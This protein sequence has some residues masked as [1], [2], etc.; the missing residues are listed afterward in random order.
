MFKMDSSVMKTGSFYRIKC[1][2]GEFKNGIMF[3]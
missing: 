1:R 2:D 3:V